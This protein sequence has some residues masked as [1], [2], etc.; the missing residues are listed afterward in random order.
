MSETEIYNKLIQEIQSETSNLVHG[1]AIN[2][3]NIIE[4]VLTAISLVNKYVH[5]TMDN[6]KAV[7]GSVLDN[8]LNNTPGVQV[9]DR[10][11]VEQFITNYLYSF[12]EGLQG[13]V[14]GKYNI[15]AEFVK[16]K[17]KIRDFFLCNKQS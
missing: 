7:L 12:L 14:S 5:D 16:C 8:L 6:K 13:I 17:Q 3:G 9:N 4:I 10:T 2:P 1:T 11:L 15:K